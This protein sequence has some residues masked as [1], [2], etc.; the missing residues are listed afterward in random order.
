MAI[1]RKYQKTA[2]LGNEFLADTGNEYKVVAQRAYIDKKGILPNGVILTLQ[3]IHDKNKYNHG[4][5]DMTFQTFD[6]YVLCGAN[7]VG[8]KKG[9]LVSLHEF[10]EDVSY[11][12][13]FDYILR[14][15]EVTKIEKSSALP[16]LEK[17]K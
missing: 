12:I 13:N 10:M 8:V 9:D 4:E 1:K 7:D 3:I 14:F 11:Y 17:S 15:R 5:D 16:N 6:V 2:V